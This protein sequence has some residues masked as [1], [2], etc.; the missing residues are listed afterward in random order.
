MI[1]RLEWLIGRICCAL[2]NIENVTCR[3]NRP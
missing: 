1:E 2:F 3:G